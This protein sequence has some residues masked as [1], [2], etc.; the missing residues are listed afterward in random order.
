MIRLRKFTWLLVIFTLAVAIQ[1]RPALGASPTFGEH[2]MA[3]SAEPL[4]TEVGLAILKAGGNA[5][6]AAAAMGFALAVTYPQAGNLG[7][8]GFCVALTSDGKTLAL[9]F[10]EVAPG[11]AT[12]DMFLDDHIMEM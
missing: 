4:A 3:V 10:R 8:G 11:A 5:F 2:G 12:R 9:D 1:S 6:D 7:G